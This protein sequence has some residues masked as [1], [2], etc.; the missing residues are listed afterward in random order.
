MKIRKL[1]FALVAMAVLVCNAQAQDFG[2]TQDDN[3]NWVRVDGTPCNGTIVTAVPFLR[4]V[5][6]ARNGGMGDL[7]IA[8]SPDANSMHFNQSNL[9]FAE[10][11]FGVSATYTPWLRALGVNDVYLAYLSGYAKL[12]KNQALGLGVKFFSLGSI[13]FTDINGNALQTARPSEF[14][15]DLAYSRKLGKNFSAGLGVKYIYSRLADG[16]FQGGSFRPGS[17][18]ATDLS[19][20]FNK[21]F[22]LNDKKAKVTAAL[23]MTNMGT[24]ISYSQNG[25]S[26]YIPSNLGLGASFE[27]NFDDHNSIAVGLDLNKLMVP[28]PV[29]RYLPVGN[30]VPANTPNPEY[31][32][33]DGDGTGDNIPDYK[34][35]S[36]FAALFGSFGDAPGGFTEEMREWMISTGVE[37]WYD[38]QFSVRGGYYWEHPTKGARSFFSVGLG[39][40]Y[41]VFGINFSYLVP[42]NNNRNPLDN[43]LRFSLE[44]AFDKTSSQEEPKDITQ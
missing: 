31:D 11:D 22:K 16:D 13:Q 37:Y 29:P 20:T 28:T 25:Q 41:S 30:G 23:A 1:G 8:M 19:F 40:R 18:V 26:D 35:R 7:G 39:L 42:T 10:K 34:Q 12:D 44:F 32:N 15:I 17:A 36:I 9:I 43:T 24:K 14:S 38:K 21:D 3:G 2:C 4:I 27:Y 6:N 33:E 5:P